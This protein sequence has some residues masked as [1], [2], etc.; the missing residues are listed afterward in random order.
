MGFGI[1]VGPR[2]FR[3]RVSTR[4]LGVSSGIGPFSVHAHSGGRRRR[5]SMTR[6]ARRGV[7]PVADGRS[8][9]LPGDTTTTHLIGASAYQLVPTDLD[10]LVAQLNR[11]QRWITGWVWGIV[12][13]ALLSFASPLFLIPTVVALAV[14]FVGFARRRVVLHYEVDSD[15]TKWFNELVAG[16]PSLAQTNGKWRVQTSTHLHQ[17]RDR[18]M[19]AG[20]GNLVSRHNVWC[21]MNLPVVLNANVEVPTVKA[22]RHSLLFLPDRML[23]KSG[24]RWSDVY[25]NDLNVTVSQHR[26]IEDG[27][28]PRDG[29]QVGETWQYANVRGGPDRRFKDNRRL[30]VMLYTEVVL[31]SPHGLGWS[32]SLSRHEVAKW[33]QQILRARPQTPL[34]T[35]TPLTDA[36]AGPALPD[37]QTSA[38]AALAGFES[39]PVPALR[40]A[41]KSMDE[42]VP[43]SPAGR[44]LEPWGL[45]W[46][47]IEV[48]GE[49]LHEKAIAALFAGVAGYKESVGAELQEK[50]VMV[51]DPDNPHGEGHAV[52]VFVRGYH[53]GYV[54][55]QESALYFPHVS[56]MTAGGSAVTVDARVWASENAY[57]NRF[58]SR[59]TLA[60]PEPKD[61]GYPRS[62]P[63]DKN[64]VLLPSGHQLQVTGE[65]KHVDLLLPYLGE[66]VAVTLHNITIQKA[67]KPLDLVEI[68]LDRETVGRFIPATS[69]KVGPLVNCVERA[70]G[71]PVARASVA[72]NSLK[73]EVTVYVARVGDVP[74]DWFDGLWTVA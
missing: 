48:A 46:N 10:E 56:V 9:Y 29:V 38:P 74:Q 41:S 25:Y 65:E 15:L 44:P 50:A 30:P 39:D 26:F 53:I 33:W 61:F 49:S 27:S 36:P 57:G 51:P 54:P 23:V 8:M 11:A 32:L 47:R 17:T 35:S 66:S 2:L 72:G 18:K 68:R 40:R 69:A 28:V 67:G 62:M 12:A 71:L 22:K 60:V 7:S 31:S 37:E 55:H 5:R 1:S 13:C 70:G 59:V 34:L 64:A 52:A 73:A 43:P 63:A 4:G 20:A 24:S 21:P 3:V 16:W 14:A 58:C 19:N 42:Y 45:A 6:N